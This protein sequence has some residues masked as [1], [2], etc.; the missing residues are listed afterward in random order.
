[1]SAAVT[2]SFRPNVA[3]ETS[4]NDTLRCFD[5]RREIRASDTLSM[6]DREPPYAWMRRSFPAPVCAEC[7]TLDPGWLA[8]VACLECARPLRV[9][10]TEARQPWR[11]PG[12]CARRPDARAALARYRR[13]RAERLAARGARVC[14]CGAPIAETRRT[15]TLHCSAACKQRAHRRGRS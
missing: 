12:A 5:C 6:L 9:F 13:R 2:D 11:C 1:M 15:D 10:G 4:R 14:A 3:P 7:C 8:T